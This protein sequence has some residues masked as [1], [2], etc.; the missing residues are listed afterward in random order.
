MFFFFLYPSIA[1]KIDFSRQD[2]FSDR[3]SW[4]QIYDK[5]FDYSVEIMMELPCQEKKNPSNV[6]LHCC[7]TV[8]CGSL[9]NSWEH[10]YH[11]IITDITRYKHSQSLHTTQILYFFLNLPPQ[12][13]FYIFIKKPVGLNWI[14]QS[15]S[16]HQWKNK[17]FSK[18]AKNLSPLFTTQ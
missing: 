17:Y 10:R 15:N 8:Y 5:I 13:E 11:H 14:L 3:K 12:H 2:L 7:T 9:V 6:I 1:W 4:P 16:H 18:I